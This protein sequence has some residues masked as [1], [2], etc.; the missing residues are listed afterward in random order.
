M[1][2]SELRIDAL[3]LLLFT[4]LLPSKACA[5]LVQLVAERAA[6]SRRHPYTPIEPL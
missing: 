3:L 2:Y 1:Q 5:Y 6:L 4:D